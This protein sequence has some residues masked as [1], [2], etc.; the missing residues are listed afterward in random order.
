MHGR[1]CYVSVT[2]HNGLVYAIGGFDGTNRLSTVERYN[3]KKNQWTIIS[4]MI[5]PRSDASACTL[6]D[7]IYATGDKIIYDIIILFILYNVILLLDAKISQHS[8]QKLY[9][10]LSSFMFFF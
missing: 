3:P 9:N 5:V 6:K 2:E 7:R 10:L 4:P 1:R 8:P